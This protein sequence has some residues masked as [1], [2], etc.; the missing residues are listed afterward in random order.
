MS[1]FHRVMTNVYKTSTYLHFWNFRIN[2]SPYPEIQAFWLV[3]QQQQQRLIFR[4]G[5]FWQGKIKNISAYNSNGI[6]AKFY[7]IAPFSAKI[8]TYKIWSEVEFWDFEF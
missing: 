3:E 6:F 7:F 2:H 8:I 1:L 4:N 5:Q